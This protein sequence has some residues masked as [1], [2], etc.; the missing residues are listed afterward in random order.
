MIIQVF[1]ALY[2]LYKLS[3]SVI[4]ASA[5]N[6]D[7]YQQKIA[8]SEECSAA[9]CVPEVKVCNN[10][11]NKNLSA[12]SEGC[13]CFSAGLRWRSR[14]LNHRN[15]SAAYILSSHFTFSASKVWDTP[16]AADQTG[17]IT[18]VSFHTYFWQYIVQ[19]WK[20]ARLALHLCS[21]SNK[22]QSRFNRKSRPLPFSSYF[23]NL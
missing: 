2:L 23:F 3:A 11:N 7:I 5:L 22:N 4:W 12:R 8:A 1:E 21:R 16:S 9:W 10:I 6:N 18:L 15:V 14:S 19:C 20:Y 17:L 13:V